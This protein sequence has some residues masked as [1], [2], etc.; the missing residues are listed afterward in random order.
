MAGK[1]SVQRT[2]SSIILVILA[3]ATILPGGAILAV[4]L[5]IL[6]NIAFV[7]LTKACGYSAR[8][9]G[10]ARIAYDYFTNQ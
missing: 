9:R 2:V 10:Y 1:I 5:Y 7:E 8:R 3:F 6:S 4:T